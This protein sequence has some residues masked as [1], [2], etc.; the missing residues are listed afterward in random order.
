MKH[1]VMYKMNSADALDIANHL[2][3][4]DP[5]FNPS[6][7]SRLLINTYANKLFEKSQRFEFWDDCSL[8]G[9]VAAYC[10]DPLQRTSFIT[11]VS[12]IPTYHGQGLAKKLILICIDHLKQKSFTSIELEVYDQNNIAKNLYHNLGFSESHNNGS[13]LTLTLP[14]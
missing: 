4:C 9:L 14:I 12:I 2:H 11:S 7:S 13:Y 1:N 6:L 5:Y 3:I 10:N 8:I